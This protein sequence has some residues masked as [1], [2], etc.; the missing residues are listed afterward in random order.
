MLI[1]VEE[2]AKAVDASDRSA[3]ITG[4]WRRVGGVEVETAVGSG[5]VVVLT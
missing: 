4:P 2:A 3:R 1:F 5:G